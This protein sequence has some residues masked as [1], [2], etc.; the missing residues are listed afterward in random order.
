MT[1]VLHTS[2]RVS[3]IYS[4]KEITQARKGVVLQNTP[5]PDQCS[6]SVGPQVT[7]IMQWICWLNRGSRPYAVE[8]LYLA[9]KEGTE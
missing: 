3:G 4:T 8:P 5:N 7:G 2:S 9:V 6:S 1:I